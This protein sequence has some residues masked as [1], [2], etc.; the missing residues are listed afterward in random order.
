MDGLSQLQKLQENE[1]LISAKTLLFLP[2][3]TQKE[4]S[5]K[6]CFFTTAPRTDSDF[7]LA[8]RVQKCE[9]LILKS[10]AHKS[11]RWD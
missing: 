2:P 5:T 3:A 6:P 11:L 9:Y 4:S 8:R 1:I 10:I 7:R